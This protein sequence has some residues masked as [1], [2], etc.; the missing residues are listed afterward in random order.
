MTDDSHETPDE[1]VT[2]S[3]HDPS[4][5][6]KEKAAESDASSR[7]AKS[8]DDDDPPNPQDR[9]AIAS[10]RAVKTDVAAVEW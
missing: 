8:G 7:K 9:G 2:R 5:K 4:D 3:Q 6:A 1:E 10:D